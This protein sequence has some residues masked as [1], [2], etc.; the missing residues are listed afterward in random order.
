MKTSFWNLIVIISIGFS[1]NYAFHLYFDKYKS[2]APIWYFDLNSRYERR[3][4]EEIG[5][6]QLWF[7]AHALFLYVSSL[8]S[9]KFSNVFELF[10]TLSR[11]SCVRGTERIRDSSERWMQE[12]WGKYMIELILRYDRDWFDVTII[13]LL[14]AWYR[15]ATHY[16]FIVHTHYDGRC[17]CVQTV[18]FTLI[19][20]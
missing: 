5:T 11:S 6:L 18:H 13:P 3:R 16:A 15:V 19:R 9:W 12:E 1:G 20:K 8:L 4:E 17:V 2:F 10:F 14:F 7:I